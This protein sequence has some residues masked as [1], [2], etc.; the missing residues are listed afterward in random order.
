MSSIAKHFECTVAG[1]IFNLQARK[2][3]MNQISRP[4][5]SRERLEFRCIGWNIQFELS[6]WGTIHVRYLSG[7]SEF[8]E[9]SQNIY[10]LY[11]IS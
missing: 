3:K 4:L 7:T 5:L 1:S 11:E 10:V 2:C 6:I 8:L 9:I